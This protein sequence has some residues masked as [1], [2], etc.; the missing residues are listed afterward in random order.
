MEDAVA[1]IGVKRVISTSTE[2]F[3]RVGV[4]LRLEVDAQAAAAEV[5][6][7]V[8]AIRGALPPDIEDPMIQRFDVAALPVMVYAVGSTLPSDR[9]RRLVDDKLK[10]LLEQIDGVAAVE[11]NGGQTP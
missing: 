6:E 11:I 8:A 1:G 3:S 5:R 2:G 9:V 4:E 7:K 10:P